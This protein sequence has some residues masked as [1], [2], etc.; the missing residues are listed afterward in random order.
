MSRSSNSNRTGR[1]GHGRRPA[2]RRSPRRRSRSRRLLLG[3]VLTLGGAAFLVG[4][5]SGVTVVRLDRTVTQRFEGKRFNS[6]ND[7]WIDALR[8]KRAGR[9]GC[10]YNAACYA[11]GQRFAQ[12][13]FERMSKR[14]ALAAELLQRAASAYRESADAMQRVSEV[15][16][17]TH[18]EEG[19]I[20]DESKIGQ[21]ADLLATARDAEADAIATL[22]E[23]TKI[24]VQRPP[25][26]SP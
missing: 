19:R 12:L 6:L 23:V 16:P 1:S 9:F 7:L 26:D 15:F 8:T 5:V 10:G 3:V 20:M 21:A 2:R 14:R 24:Q 18:D 4:I 13:F 22:L 17:F 25:A 11:E